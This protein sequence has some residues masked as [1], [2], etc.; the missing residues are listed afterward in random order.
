MGGKGI[1]F[2]SVLMNYQLSAMNFFVGVGDRLSTLVIYVPICG[3]GRD[4]M[5]ILLSLGVPIVLIEFFNIVLGFFSACM[6][7]VGP[8]AIFPR[9]V[10]Y[11]WTVYAIHTWS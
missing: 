3:L 11:V 4:S 10:G 7:G 9:S 2:S 5:P 1:E 6:L 8:R